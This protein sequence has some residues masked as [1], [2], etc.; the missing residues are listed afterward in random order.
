MKV[1]TKKKKLR[2]LPKLIRDAEKVFNEWVRRRA[3]NGEEYFTCM[4]CLLPK[5]KDELN[6]G[7]LIPVCKSSFLKFHPDNVW[8]ECQGCNAYDQ[9]KVNYTINLIK[10]IGHERVEW[11]TNNKRKGHKWDRSDLE[12]IIKQYS[13]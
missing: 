11:L 9:S 3:L 8:G 4:N 7:H 12:E 13:L 1:K 6:A 5:S 2:P 10:H